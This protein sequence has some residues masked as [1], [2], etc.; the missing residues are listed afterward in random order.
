[1]TLLLRS[2][3][4]LG[5]AHR[6][7]VIIPSYTCYSVAAAVIKAGL[8]PRI[9]DI[10]PDTLDYESD[11]LA[12]TD[13]RRVLAIVATNLYG[14]PNDLPAL[15]HAARAHGAFLIDDAAQA[16]GASVGGRS[17]GTWGDAGLFSFDKGKNVSAIDGG[18]VIAGSGLLAGTIAEEL[19]HH[20]SPGARESAVHL[21]KAVAYL[22]LL[23]PWLY[24]IPARMPQL[25]LGKTVFT[26]DFPLTPPDPLLAAL[27]RTMMRRLDEFT[28]ARV[29][30]ASTLA[31]RLSN[32]PFR[33]VTPV[34]GSTAVYLRFPVI[35]A[36][37]ELRDSALA[38]L[39]RGGA[40]ASESY[41]ESLAD[42]PEVRAHLANPECRADGGRYVARRILTL[43]THPFVTRH[44]LDAMTATLAAIAADSAPAVAPQFA[45]A[46]RSVLAERP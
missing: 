20:S 29:S 38:A 41:P 37:P 10:A 31:S 34:R 43:P 46:R 11:E 17:S 16:M 36:T 3:R 9:V 2:L 23:R 32:L 24:G 7:E 39:R 8:R 45:A 25:G 35:S 6:D 30:N 1:M 5:A 22:V 13:F 15:L 27:A 19:A 18:V 4:R 44:D 28:R 12:R 21:A 26:T 14:L 42:V 40:G 33:P